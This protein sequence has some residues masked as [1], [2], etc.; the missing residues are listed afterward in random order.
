VFP[1]KKDSLTAP[2]GFILS[3]VDALLRYYIGVGL[4]RE[5]VSCCSMLLLL[6]G[7]ASE[8]AV[9]V[10]TRIGLEGLATRSTLG[11]EEKPDDIG[12]M[13]MVEQSV[14]DDKRA[15]QTQ[16]SSGLQMEGGRQK[17]RGDC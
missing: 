16:Q 9:V 11:E 13:G 3:Y 12:R 17:M 6:A 5:G 15:D 10:W 1:G 4:T 8:R 2:Y 7:R 14:R